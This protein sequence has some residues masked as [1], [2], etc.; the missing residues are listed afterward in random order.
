GDPHVVTLRQL[1]DR[2]DLAVIAVHDRVPGPQPLRV[3]AQGLIEP[4]ADHHRDR[5]DDRHQY[6][7]PRGLRSRRPGLAGR[8]AAALSLALALALGRGPGSGLGVGVA[9][10]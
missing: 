1:A 2:T 8:I 6:C 7:L 3:A 10:S 9:L 4:L 5:L